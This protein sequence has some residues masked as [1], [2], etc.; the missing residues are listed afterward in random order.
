MPGKD[1]NRVIDA[2][3]QYFGGGVVDISHIKD[4]HRHKCPNKKCRHVWKH[5]GNSK[6][7]SKSKARYEAA[8]KCP[9]CGTSQYWRL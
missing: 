5:D 6:R 2:L 7:T 4:I 1:I 3:V 9:R 8:H